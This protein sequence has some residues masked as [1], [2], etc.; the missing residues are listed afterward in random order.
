[1]F[2]PKERQDIEQKALE[3][4]LEQARRE[5]GLARAEAESLMPAPS[6]PWPFALSEDDRAFLRINKIRPA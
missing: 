2:S 3:Q 1:M 4:A 5:A 6:A